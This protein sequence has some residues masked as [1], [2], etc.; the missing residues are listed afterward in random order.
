MH[1]NVSGNDVSREIDASEFRP[2]IS[3][4]YL[5]CVHASNVEGGER[6]ENYG[7][8]QSPKS[9]GLLLEF[10]GSTGRC[11][12]ELDLHFPRELLDRPRDGI[13]ADVGALC[14]LAPWSGIALR[15]PRWADTLI[16]P[17]KVFLGLWFVV[18]VFEPCLAN[19]LPASIALRPSPPQDFSFDLGPVVTRPQIIGDFNRYQRARF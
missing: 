12:R 19:R 14:D 6:K 3:R 7:R 17:L 18:P 5:L 15:I 13:D 9:V 8:A 11:L 2:Q 4:R 10:T 1:A 16:E